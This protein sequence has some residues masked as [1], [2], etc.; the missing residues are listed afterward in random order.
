MTF[1]YPYATIRPME[2]ILTYQI[3]PEEAGQTVE[4]FLKKRGYSRHVLIHLRKNDLGIRIGGSHVYTTHVLVAGEI[5]CIC[6]QEEE[7]S[8]NI[9]ATPMELDIVYEDEDL[10]VINKPADMP[11]HPSQGNYDNTLANGLCWY[12]EQKGEPFVYRAINRLD[13]DTTGLLILAKNMLS[14]CILASM[15]KQRQIHREYLAIALGDVP[16][17]GT[18]DAPIARAE[19]STIAREINFERGESAVTHYTCL[20]KSQGISLV[21]LRLDTGRTHQIRVHMKHIGHPLLGDF[22]YFPDFSLIGRQALHS[23]R[24]SFPHPIT[25]EPMDFSAELPADMRRILA[26]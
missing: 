23:H 10:F 26:R 25:G 8:P 7:S 5:L 21:S 13:R 14:A 17:S 4:S 22:L 18:I 9:V 20:Q 11:I 24:L 2:R 1:P 12:Y 19:G 16:E 15:I 3:E 6:I